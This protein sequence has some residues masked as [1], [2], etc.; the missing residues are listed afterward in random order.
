MTISWIFLI[1]ISKGKYY[2]LRIFRGHTF[3]SHA[4]GGGGGMKNVT[5]GEWGRVGVLTCCD[6]TPSKYFDMV[7][8]VLFIR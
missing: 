3:I 7:F 4:G 2:P 5:K 1:S 6:V 8:N